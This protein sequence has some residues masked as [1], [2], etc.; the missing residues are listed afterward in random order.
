[1]SVSDV[2]VIILSVFF[3]VIGLLLAAVFWEEVK[4]LPIWDRSA[5]A[6]GIIDRG[7]F[8]I[9]NTGDN[10]V[11]ILYV[12]LLMVVL[13]TSLLSRAHIVF[14]PISILVALAMLVASYGIH[15]A[16]SVFIEN[17]Q[18]ANV[19]EHFPKSHF[20]LWNLTT[21][22]WIWTV[23]IGIILFVNWRAG[24]NANPFFSA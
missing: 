18:I 21:L 12:G 20:V 16:Y 10:L 23:I 7:T 17:G 1:M 11:L 15:E 9:E 19:L 3:L 6:T 8:F 22:S 24:R 13:A 14:I 2:L 4:D 5:T